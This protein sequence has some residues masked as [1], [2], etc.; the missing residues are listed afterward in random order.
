MEE[1]DELA[2]VIAALST[3]AGEKL[4]KRALGG[5]YPDSSDK[6][7]QNADDSGMADGGMGEEIDPED[8]IS[9]LSGVSDTDL[10]KTVSPLNKLLHLSDQ[11][12]TSRPYNARMLSKLDDADIKKLLDKEMGV[13]ERIAGTIP[14]PSED[15]YP[16]IARDP[17]ISKNY[18][19][20][21]G[22]EDA[23]DVE[24]NISID[25][26]D[27][28]DD[29]YEEPTNS[30]GGM[31]GEPNDDLDMGVNDEPVDDFELDMGLGT[32]DVTDDP[33]ELI[34]DIIKAQ[35]S[36]MSNAD[37]IYDENILQNLPLDNLKRVHAKVVG[38]GVEED[39]ELAG[40]RESL[41]RD[42]PV[43]N[44]SASPDEEFAKWMD[45]INKNI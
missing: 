24:G 17:E 43:I 13:A 14:L 27:G 32:N 37:R 30:F 40:L 23:L 7:Y 15:D 22:D 45:I 10:E 38:G 8:D 18:H 29:V 16:E 35:D 34:G 25:D 2:P 6:S 5:A 1:L 12:K 36:G 41:V 26:L 39:A 42:V 31:E 19:D 3:G 44:K 20:Y 28:E 4:A 11:G 21:Y 9:H 33:S